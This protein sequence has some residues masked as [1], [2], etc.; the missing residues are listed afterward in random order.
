[1]QSL[2]S[3]KLSWWSRNVVNVSCRWLSPRAE[4]TF[5]SRGEEQATPYHRAWA[6]QINRRLEI[7][8][9]FG[10]AWMA[11]QHEQRFP[12]T[13]LK[14]FPKRNPPDKDPLALIPRAV[15]GGEESAAQGE[16][17][18]DL[19]DF[20]RYRQGDSMRLILWKLVARRGSQRSSAGEK[21]YYVRRPEVV[22]DTRLALYFLTADREDD[23]SAELALYFLQEPLRG[24]TAWV[25][26]FSTDK[27][28]AANVDD[29]ERLLLKSGID[30]MVELPIQKFMQTVAQSGITTCII[31]LPLDGSVVQECLGQIRDAPQLNV[32]PLVAFRGKH[33]EKK[34]N[35][36][37]QIAATAPIKA[38][39]KLVDLPET[40]DR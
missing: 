34:A 1:V 37:K 8:D 13:P 38:E 14:V 9:P 22:T 5:S 20:D 12:I 33:E 17:A 26:G 4:V 25:M 3:W 32:F 40:I 27:E 15:I 24:R 7:A 39:C 28:P 16:R 6:K 35:E 36:I 19:L 31:F 11:F 29:S 10:L 2:T 23:A 18:G 30:Q 21:I